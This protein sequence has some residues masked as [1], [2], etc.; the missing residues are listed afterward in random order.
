MWSL[1][2]NICDLPIIQWD[3]HKIIKLS[4]L[5]PA[6]LFHANPL[7]YALLYLDSFSICDSLIQPVFVDQTWDVQKL[8]SWHLHFWFTA[9]PIRKMS[10]LFSHTIV[11]K[12]SLANPATIQSLFSGWQANVY[13]FVLSDSWQSP[14]FA[15]SLRGC[16]SPCWNWMRIRFADLNLWWCCRTVWIVDVNIEPLDYHRISFEFFSVESESIIKISSFWNRQKGNGHSVQMIIQRGNV[17]KRLLSHS[18]KIGTI[19]ENDFLSSVTIL[20]TSVESHHHVPVRTSLNGRQRRYRATVC[21]RFIHRGI[22]STRT[23]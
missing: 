21:R 22:V 3:K 18:S 20:D 9:I 14:V 15:H 23:W 5:P 4:L 10:H 16:N 12:G 7:F 13:Y 2:L 17:F 11:W 19:E 8:R 1:C 6:P